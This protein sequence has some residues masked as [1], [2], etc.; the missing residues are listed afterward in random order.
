M[1]QPAMSPDKAAPPRAE[2]RA[3]RILVVDD[4]ADAAASLGRLLNLSGYEIRVAN[5]GQTALDEVNGFCPHVVLLDLGMPGM[6]GLETASR[7]RA[8][9]T[10]K[11][12]SLIA[13]TG[14]G[15]D[16][17]RQ[18]TEAAGFVAHFVKPIKINQLEALLARISGANSQLASK[19][20]CPS[21][22]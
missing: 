15:Q 18:R 1:P 6:D 16:E 19:T 21:S 20:N 3:H 2:P 8:L 14:W 22:P 7:I 12:L 11:D 9:P 13:V 4:N 10:G 17:D 5:D